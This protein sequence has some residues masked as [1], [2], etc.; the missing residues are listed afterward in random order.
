MTRE[1]AKKLIIYINPP[2]AEAGNIKQR[3]GTGQNKTSVALN[4]IHD[5]YHFKLSG[6]NRQLFAQFLIRVYNEIPDCKIGEFSTLKTL[7][8]SHFKNFR[9]NFKAKLL[10]AFIV[11]AASFD[12]VNGQFPIG[13]KIWDTKNK[14]N[15]NKKIA[16]VYDVNGNKLGKKGFYSFKGFDYFSKWVNSFK[17]QTGTLLLGWL[18]G[19]TRNDFQ[20][21]NGI[22]I[23]NKKEQIAVPRGIVIF[24]ENIVECCVCF[25]VRMCISAD[26]L[27]DCDQFLYPNN[28]W[29]TDE[30]FQNDCLAYTLFNNN[31]QSK[32]GTNHWIPFMEEEV[33]AKNKFE[34]HFIVR[35]ITGKKIQNRYANLFDN[36][37]YKKREFSETAQNVF[38]AGRELW[39]YYHAQPNVNV[40]ASLYDIREHFQGRSDKG[41][42]NSKS[43]DKTYN[44]LIDN[45]RATLKTL[46]KKIEPKVYEYGFLRE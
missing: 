17:I 23:R 26:W 15:F 7:S 40:N 8:S 6:A 2:Y 38:N 45:L 14:E 22:T 28:K 1:S 24:D 27:N 3:I 19:V 43:D 10:S 11:P 37:K 18:Q 34:S 16:D 20:N 9:E 4:K 41:I 44:E 36:E 33:D 21:Q 35:F 31:I 32:H 5:K 46:A 42:M 25:A 13:F 30:D 29:K 12:N 39:K